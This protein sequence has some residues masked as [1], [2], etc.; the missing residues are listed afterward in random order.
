M[1]CI[2]LERHDLAKNLHRFYQLLVATGIFGNWSLVR[3][4]G[5]VDSSGTVL[6]DWF[7]NKEDAV[8]AQIIFCKAK[9]KKGYISCHD[10]PLAAS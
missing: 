3:E 7:K 10:Y 1:T 8:A 6:K 4:W 2:Y 9:R 5:W